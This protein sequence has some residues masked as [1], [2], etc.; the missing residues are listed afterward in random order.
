MVL[1]QNFDFIT[2]G[3]K[4][5]V[6]F[7][8]NRYA[9][10]ENS[11]AYTPY[12]YGVGWYNPREDTYKIEPL[13][14]GE[15]SIQIIGDGREDVS[16]NFYLEA[17]TNY[18]RTF[19]DKHG[20]SA[21]L[22]YQMRNEKI[23][24][25]SDLQA[26]LPYR[27][28]GLAGRA[29]YAY[30]KRYFL[31]F[32]FGYNGS[33][34]FDESHRYGF[35]PSVGAG[36]TIS[37]EG[38]WAGM[39]DK[40]NKVK[41]RGSYGVVG[42]DAIG[43][44]R[45]FYLSNVNVNNSAYGVSFGR[46]PG[47]Y[48]K[49][50]ISIS[51][52]PNPAI[53]WEKAFKTNIAL[54]VGLFESVNIIAEYF[55]ERR[56][57]I[58]MP[59]ASVPQSMGLQAGISA[60]VGEAKGSG[61]DLSADYQKYFRNDMWLSARANFTYATNEYVAYEEPNYD[62]DWRSH[63]G[64]SVQQ[65]RGYIAER[66]FLDDAEVANSPYQPFGPYGAGDIKY[67]DVNKDGEISSADMVPIGNP[68][69]PEIVYG[70]G[71]SYGYKGVDIST[72]FQGLTNRSFWIDPVKTAP[73]HNEQQVLQEYADSYWSETNNDVYAMWPHLTYGLSGNNSQ[74]S[75]WFMRDGSFLRL[76]QVELGYKLPDTVLKKLNLGSCRFYVS[77]NN[78]FTFTGFKMWDVEMGGN[79]LGY[80]IQRTFNI[81]IN[82]SY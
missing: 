81:G 40:V 12:Y 36:W 69:T 59:R 73:F 6:M 18:D 22:V 31:E 52:Y 48:N 27:N 46:D 68:T 11:R 5:R 16:S 82:L 74:T 35:F 21:L 62:E 54:E 9:Y 57:Q 23:A 26:S 66:L 58:L 65:T 38:F 79:G 20:V 13:R 47:S 45:F 63:I 29:T 3:L 24:N 70:F 2:E 77:A 76:K 7:N 39:K 8:T 41:L 44:Q 4:A 72:F 49:N 78:L 51:Q 28:V 1:K 37:N 14:E 80:P 56:T 10:F 25:P 43:K 15:E 55:E 42:N 32:N 53:T 60:N 17:V 75:T 34:R 67:T 64:Y 30:D 61:F 71:F 50:G 19:N 33:E